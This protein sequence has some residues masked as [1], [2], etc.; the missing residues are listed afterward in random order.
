MNKL[1][2]YCR[3]FLEYVENNLREGEVIEFL[4]REGRSNTWHDDSNGHVLQ[5]LG[6]YTR[7]IEQECK[8]IYGEN[9]RSIGV[10]FNKEFYI[11]EIIFHKECHEDIGWLEFYSLSEVF[12]VKF[13]EDEAKMQ[14]NDNQQETPK[15]TST[16]LNELLEQYKEVQKQIEEEEASMRQPETDSYR[17]KEGLI[18]KILEA[19]PIQEGDVVYCTNDESQT[20]C[21]VDSI[22][23]EDP[24]NNGP[25]VR[26]CL[27]KLFGAGL[28]TLSIN[29]NLLVK[30]PQDLDRSC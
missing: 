21:K 30:Q 9:S 10:N 22:F 1:L 15:E 5:G 14:T 20:L 18:E 25:H 6:F 13:L 27:K 19:S 7:R 11:F 4:S 3:Q 29:T 17:K 24:Y 2:K 28:Y 8:D 26:A 16:L 12:K 23:V